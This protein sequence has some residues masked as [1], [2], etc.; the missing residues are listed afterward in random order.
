M[1]TTSDFDRQPPGETALQQV[2]GPSPG[3]TPAVLNLHLAGVEIVEMIVEGWCAT[4][5]NGIPPTNYIGDVFGSLGGNPDFGPGSIFG[6]E[7]A[8]K[9]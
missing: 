9:A 4:F 1:R 2:L 6:G 5:E 3:H 8:N 7:L